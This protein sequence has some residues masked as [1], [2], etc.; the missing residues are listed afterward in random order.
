[1]TSVCRVSEPALGITAYVLARVRAGQPSR[2]PVQT[3]PFTRLRKSPLLLAVC[4]VILHP[5]VISQCA[6]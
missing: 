6:P 3:M 5:G 2:V 4:L 1:M